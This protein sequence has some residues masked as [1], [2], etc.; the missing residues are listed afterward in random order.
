M[1]CGRAYFACEPEEK[2]IPYVVGWIGED[3][4]LYASDYPHWD[5]EWPHTVDTLMKRDDLNPRV[6]AK[7]LGG[8]ALGFYGLKAP[9]VVPEGAAVR[10]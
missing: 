9:A 3:H 10:A 8:N 1:T 5:S 6:K 2:T 4:I 7:I